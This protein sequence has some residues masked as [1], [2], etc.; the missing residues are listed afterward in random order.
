MNFEH[1]GYNFGATYRAKVFGGWVVTFEAQKTSHY[2]GATG[3]GQ[4][5]AVFVP[6]PNHEW[7]TDQ[8]LR[9]KEWARDAAAQ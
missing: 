1:M 9:E 2:G 8:E 5:V 3:S 7:L 4:Y 6:D